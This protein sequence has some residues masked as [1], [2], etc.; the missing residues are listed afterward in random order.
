MISSGLTTMS[1]DTEKALKSSVIVLVGIGAI[2]D[3]ILIILM[4]K[5]ADE[6]NLFMVL[7]ISALIGV[8]AF[9]IAKGLASISKQNYGK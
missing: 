4:F 1:R 7:L 5:F 2:I 8:V 6:E 3:V 9:G